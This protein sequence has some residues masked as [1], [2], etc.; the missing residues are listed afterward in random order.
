[1]CDAETMERRRSQ[2]RIFEAGGLLQNGQRTVLSSMLCLKEIINCLWRVI[3]NCFDSTRNEQFCDIH[4]VV[5]K[6]TV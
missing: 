3:E 4:R 6:Y 5:Y 2:L 1:M